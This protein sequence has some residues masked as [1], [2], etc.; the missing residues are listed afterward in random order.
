M[1]SIL[2]Y[3]LTTSFTCFA[4]S[5][6]QI[7]A[8]NPI[9][10]ISVVQEP[11]TGKLI[12][13]ERMNAEGLFAGA[14]PSC[15]YDVVSRQCRPLA[16]LTD[17]FC[18]AGFIS[19]E[20]SGR[21]FNIGGWNGPSLE[22][23]RTFSPCGIP[24][25]F[26]QCIW[27]E[28]Q[29]VAALQVPRWYPTA[30]PLP[31]GRVLILGGSTAVTGLQ[32][33]AQD[34]SN[35]EFIPPQGQGVL[36]LGILANAPGFSNYPLAHVLTNGQLWIM[37]GQTS[38]IVDS[39]TLATINNLP[40]IPDGARTYPLTGSSV[41]LALRPKTNYESTVLVC[42]GST[43]YNIDAA[44]LSSCGSIT[45]LSPA[46]NW[47]MEQMPMPRLMPDMQLLPDGTVLIINGAAT[48]WAGFASQ[49]N[50]I[51]QSVLYDPRLPIGKRFTLQATSTIARMYHSESLLVEDGTVMILGS[52]PNSD[53]N[54]NP[55]TVPYPNERRVEV[56][57]PAYLLSGLKRPVIV[58][59]VP[60]QWMYNQQVTFYATVPSGKANAITA[61]LMTNG[62]VTHSLHMGQRMVELTLTSVYN[63]GYFA[64]TVISPPNSDILPPGWYMLF[65]MDG[66]TPAVATWI[67]VGGDPANVGAF[68]P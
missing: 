15:E 18:S 66:P 2:F 10:P 9:A 43:G 11:R 23:V 34:Q 67:Q 17:A 40:N 32:P 5:T 61:V 36:A 1:N 50:P 42:G 68:A 63:N 45:P 6:I 39:N 31:N 62:F 13:M 44:A 12:L 46:P 37:A 60:E 16:M 29:N 27:A 33:P 25:T 30:V 14:Q 65:V 41:L 58:G 64:I 52:T 4:Q 53:D 56:F 35:A 51:Y 55:A 22:A 3:F 21:L 7:V 26:G 28:N 47:I 20:G 24:G 38:Q 19:P 8:T 57:T 59:Q 48:G 49:Q 54:Y